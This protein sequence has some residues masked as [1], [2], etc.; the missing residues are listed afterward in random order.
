MSS[1]QI[2][3]KAVKRKND[4]P[5]VVAMV[6][7]VIGYV[8]F[9]LAWVLGIVKSGFNAGI[10]VLAVISTVLLVNFTWKYFHLEYEYAFEN[11]TLTVAKI[12]G[13][14]SRR[15]EARA[16]ISDG[17]LIAPASAEN[18][19]RLKGY[20]ADQTLY[21]I[22]SEKAENIWFALFEERSTQN[23]TCIFFEADE[24]SIAILRHY[25]PRATQRV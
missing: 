22:S 11:G 10:A 14:R 9:D 12:Y 17:I 6:M 13:K 24:R 20:E 19:A 8:C 16:E 1:I 23:R 25:N 18:M 4:T 7:T 3:E 2:Y 21:A 15:V 5:R